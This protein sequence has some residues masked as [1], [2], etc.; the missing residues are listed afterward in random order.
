MGVAPA[1]ASAIGA[2]VGGEL[3]VRLIAWDGSV[4]G[5]ATAPT[6]RL[7]SAMAL[8]RLLWHPGELGAAQ[9]YVCGDLDVDGDL[10][11]A[12]SHVWSE[13][14]ERR[15]TS[16]R[17]SP[18][19]IVRLVAVATKLG[20]LRGPPSPPATQA[21]MRGR[22]HSFSRDSRAIRH[23]YDLSNA[24]YGLILDPSMAYSCAYWEDGSPNPVL[25]Q[26]QYDKL[27][28][29]CRKL[30][31]DERPGM[32]LLDVGCGWGSL[33]LHAAEQYGA[34]VVGVTLSG[35]QKA[36]I[37]AALTER[38]L[39]DR[40]SVRVQDYRTVTDGPFDAAA[41]I[42]MGEHVGLANYPAYARV[43]HNCVRP[44][45]RVL[46]QQM[47]RRGSHPGGG[48][49]IESFIAPDMDMRPLGRTV[50]LLEDAGLAT[51]S[52]QAMREHYVRTA[53]AWIENLEKHWEEAVSMIGEEAARVW[54]LYLAGGRL[55]FMQGRM[56]VDQ[57]L[58]TRPAAVAGG[59]TR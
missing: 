13:I 17:A 28:R 26:A 22:L 46:I 52:V 56:G 41:S 43:L 3:P 58:L 11:S 8:R 12:L 57:I 34:Q 25:A 35:E 45:A 1:L 48:P 6:V 50:A 14:A 16:I 2:L 27:D 49:F 24:F 53:Q 30:G 23:H 39:G 47:S 9:A 10:G 40:V 42:E 37:E 32:R 21:R 55:A 31:L 29:I 59:T 38:G 36:Y 4:A 15:L 7:R 19:A 54:R 20:A 33:T 44:G 51:I 5:P 18:W